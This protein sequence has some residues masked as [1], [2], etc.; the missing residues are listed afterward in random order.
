MTCGNHG[1]GAFGDRK[2][3]IVDASPSAPHKRHTH[4][5]FTNCENVF[6][7]HFA[8]TFNESVHLLSSRSRAVG[9]PAEGRKVMV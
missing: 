7:L 6:L 4:R 8:K 1:G 5:T 2:V 9:V 3:V